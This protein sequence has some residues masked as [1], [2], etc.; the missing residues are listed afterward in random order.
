MC[1]LFWFFLRSKQ[2]TEMLLFFLTATDRRLLLMQRP[3]LDVYFISCQAELLQQRFRMEAFHARLPN[4]K[5]S[6]PLEHR[7]QTLA[8][9]GPLCNYIW[10]AR[11]YKVTTRDGPLALYST[12]TI[13]TT[14]PRMLGWYFVSQD[15]KLIEGYYY[16]WTGLLLLLCI[17]IH[18]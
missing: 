6:K 10:P 15:R 18:Y 14:N 11:K 4:R 8:K 12:C 2:T 17:Q 16:Y 9:F 1:V 7:C 5:P 13:N 3:P